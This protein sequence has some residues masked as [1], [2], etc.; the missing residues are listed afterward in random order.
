MIVSVNDI[1]ELFYM[2]SEMIKCKSIICAGVIVYLCLLSVAN[3][4]PSEEKFQTVE[5]LLTVS[6][7]AQRIKVSDNNVAKTKQASAIALFEQAKTAAHKGEGERADT[8]LGDATK[9][10]FSATRMIEKNKDIIKKDLYDFDSRL[11]SI[12]ALCDAYHNIRK[13]KGLGDPESSDLYPFVQT[14]IAH[15]KELK[16][17]ANLKEGRKVLD[18]AYVAAK[19]AI[20]HLR[21]GETLV[22]ALNFDTAEDEYHYEVD[23]NDTHRMLVDILLKEKMKSG[24]NVKSMVDKFMDEA[25]IL[26]KVAD[27]QAINGKYKAAVSTLE[28]STKEIV[29]A[30]RSAGIYIPG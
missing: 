20:E 21:G 23:R 15:A 11:A 2:V 13:E 30:I 4:M 12:D 26:R 3:A 28:Q 18:E 9:M 17:Q 8:L 29:R 7:A 5:K 27:E 6:S 22:R 25:N 16:Q 19:V 1:N 14:R 24:G 10:M